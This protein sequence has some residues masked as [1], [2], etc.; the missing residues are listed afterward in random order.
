MILPNSNLKVKVPPIKIQGIKTKLIPFIACSIKWDGMGTWIEPFMG[1]GAVGFNIA[2]EHA[3]FSDNNPY[4]IKFYKDLQDNKFDSQDV[5][6]YLISEGE[7]LSR[8]SEGTDSY[9]YE[10]RDR[11][12]ETH[13]SLD[14]LFLQRSNFNGMIR[15]GPHGY[16][17][18]FGRKPDRFRPALITKICNQIDWV[19]Y[20]MQTHDWNFKVCNWKD[21]LANSNENDFVYLDPPYIGR[22]TKYF[23]SWTD[24]DANDLASY[25][26][27]NLL[28]GYALS[29]WYKNKYRTNEHLDLWNGTMLTNEHFYYLGGKEQNRNSVIEALV[30]KDGYVAN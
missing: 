27:Q 22:S 18:P 4:L 23:G 10:V 12:N 6:E 14:F 13:N 25:A 30:V 19:K 2:P 15:F 9:Y 11:F 20:Q 29:M 8:T 16:N 26:N 7:K 17:V 28:G 5:R 24:A 1:S 21:S 3:L